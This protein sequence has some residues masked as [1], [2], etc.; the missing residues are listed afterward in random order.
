MLT[1]SLT[2]ML[3]SYLYVFPAFPAASGIPSLKDHSCE[4]WA[5]DCERVPDTIGEGSREKRCS[6]SA[7]TFCKGDETFVVSCRPVALPASPAYWERR[8]LNRTYLFIMCRFPSARFDQ[9]ERS[10]ISDLVVLQSL[11]PGMPIDHGR[12][13]REV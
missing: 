4:N 9:N 12:H 2:G 5:G 8:C 10:A 11:F 6:R 7:F 3:R 13:P 1:N